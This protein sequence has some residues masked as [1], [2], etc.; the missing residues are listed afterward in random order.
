MFCI[1][2]LSTIGCGINFCSIHLF[3]NVIVTSESKVNSVTI[4]IQDEIILGL[5]LDEDKN[6][7]LFMPVVALMVETCQSL[8]RTCL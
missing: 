4:A 2:S 6:I 7:R 1:T 8:Q 3:G 5:I